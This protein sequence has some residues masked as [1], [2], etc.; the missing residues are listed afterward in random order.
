[1]LRSCTR[2]PDSWPVLGSSSRMARPRLVLRRGPPASKSVAPEVCICIGTH[3]ETHTVHSSLL[4]PHRCLLVLHPRL[5]FHLTSFP[6]PGPPMQEGP[7]S[8]SGR[9]APPHQILP[10]I[11]AMCCFADNFVGNLLL[12]LFSLSWCLVLAKKA[13]WSQLVWAVYLYYYYSTPTS[14]KARAL[15]STHLHAR[16]L[17][18]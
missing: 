12:L 5:S 2:G 14:E 16:S 6:I 18:P 10:S 9:S 1:M 3:R 13:P 7:R 8:S 17:A 11:S 15:R 4:S